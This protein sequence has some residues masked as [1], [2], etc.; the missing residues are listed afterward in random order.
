DQ[1]ELAMEALLQPRSRPSVTDKKKLVEV[2]LPLE[3]INAACKKDK[4]RKTNTTRSLH[5][6]FARMPVPALRALIF[7]SLVDDPGENSGREPLLRLIERLVESGTE[8]P[9][10][11]VI[12]QVR[13][14]VKES[15][16]GPVVL[17]PF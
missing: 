16:E 1:P 9:P 3:A 13:T 2:A 15:T 4:D 5:K 11:D 8:S 14:A 12:S 17:D 6:W 7:A 10:H